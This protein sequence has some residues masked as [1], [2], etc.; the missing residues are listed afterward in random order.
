MW[1]LIP[2]QLAHVHGRGVVEALPRDAEQEGV[3]VQLLFLLGG[4]LGKHLRFGRFKDAVETPGQA[5][6]S[7][8]GVTPSAGAICFAWG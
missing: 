8:G 5:C 6:T 7:A 1:V 3:R 2:H 4:E